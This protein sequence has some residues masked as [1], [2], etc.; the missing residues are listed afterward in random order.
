[1]QWKMSSSWWLSSSSAEGQRSFRFCTKMKPKP[2]SGDCTLFLGSR[3]R[4]AESL[5]VNRLDL[6]G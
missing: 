1:M 5:S 6:S 2:L 3:R 4:L